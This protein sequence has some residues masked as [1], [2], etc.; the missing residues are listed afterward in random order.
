MGVTWGPM[1]LWPHGAYRPHEP[2]GPMHENMH[3]QKIHE[4][5]P[6]AVFDHFAYA[7]LTRSLRDGLGPLWGHRAQATT[8]RLLIIHDP[9]CMHIG[10]I[11]SRPI[12]MHMHP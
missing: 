5:R 6:G 10:P 11:G 2:H 3:A 9:I 12:C 1:A 8:F 7:E 4:T